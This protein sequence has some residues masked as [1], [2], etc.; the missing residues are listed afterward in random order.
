MKRKDYNAIFNGINNL[1]KY[2]GQVTGMF[3]CDEHLNGKNPTQGSELCTVSESLFS[4]ESV[5]EVYPDQ[6]ELLD[7]IESIAYNAL[8]GTIDETF[9]SH[10]YDQQAN[11]VLVTRGKRNWYNNNDDSNLFGLEPNFVCCTANM[12]QGWPKLSYSLFLAKQDGGIMAGVYAPCDLTYVNANGI[13][14]NITE[15]TEYPFDE[16]IKFTVN[17]KIECEFEFKLRIPSW[18]NSSFVKVNGLLIDSK[19]SG[20]YSLIRRWKKGDIVELI[21]PMDV[22]VTHRYHNAISVLRGP[23][24]YALEIKESWKKLQDHSLYGD[25]EIYPDSDWNYTI[26]LNEKDLKTSFKVQKHDFLKQPFSH[27]PPVS[28][29]CKG[30]KIPNWELND[31]SAGDLPYSPVVSNEPTVDLRLIPYGGAK[32]RIS[33]IPYMVNNI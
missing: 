8:P 25:W 20:F 2:H 29:L 28:I 7:R 1:D 16:Y 18:C 15:E 10:Q 5:W 31:N 33:E 11:Q 12:H 13:Q 9:T 21:L 14:I 22:R 17:P 23:I 3:T 6:V 24:V 30:K 26:L 32:L 4:L 19:P 27:T